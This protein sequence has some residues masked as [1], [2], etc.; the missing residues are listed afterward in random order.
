MLNQLFNGHI[1]FHNGVRISGAL[2]AVALLA[3]NLLCSDKKHEDRDA[4]ASVNGQ[5]T[6]KPKV[7]RIRK[8]WYQFF[9]EPSYSTA[10]AGYVLSF[11][12]KKDA[13]PHSR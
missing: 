10:V 8:K 3:A 7:V 11:T 12:V 6:E 2:N 9:L 4:K 1:G 5:A 13:D